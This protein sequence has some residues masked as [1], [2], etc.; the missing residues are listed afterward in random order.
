MT[1]SATSPILAARSVGKRFGGV[2][3]LRDVSIEIRAGEVLAVVGEN[4]AGKSTLMKILAGV[5]PPS[6]GSMQLD[7]KPVALRNVQQALDCGIALIHQ[8]LNL[9]PNLDVAANISLGREPRRLGFLLHRSIAERAQRYLQQLGAEISPHAR[10]GTLSI[11]QQQLVEIAG[12]LSINARVLIMDEP[13]SSLSQQEADRL[14]EVIRQLRSTGV[15]IVYI[16]HR[17]HEVT[18]LADRVVV[19]RDGRAVGELAGDQIQRDRMVRMMVGRDVSQFYQRTPHPK[20]ELA[21]E[22][23]DLRTAAFPNQPLSFQLHAGEIVGLAGLMGAGRTELLTTLFGITPP[24]AGTIRVAGKTVKLRSSADA[25]ANGLALA[26]EDRRETGLLLSSSVRRN[27]SLAELGRGLQRFGL[28]DRRGEQG[29]TANYSQQ[30]AIKASDGETVVRKLSGGNQQKVVLGKW[31]ATGP[32]VLLLDEPTRGIDVGSKAE[33]YELM[34]KLASQGVAI[35][36]ASSEMEEIMGLSDR[37]LV[38]HGGEIRGK[39]SRDDLS[40]EAIMHLAV[41]DPSRV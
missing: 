18:Q 11:A 34:H 22:V 38:M 8:E 31:L 28:I 1:A 37:V 13:T 39:I 9:A 6:T 35:L 14:Y 12:S 16:S 32:R 21:L 4:G 23:A 15:A 17:L 24:V 10:L 2:H 33:I 5:L 26:P 3:A 7:G 29:L 41:G 20:G 27:L 25:I 30:L 19:L 36:F 40:E